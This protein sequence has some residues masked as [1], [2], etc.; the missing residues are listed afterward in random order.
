MKYVMIPINKK[1]CD[2]GMHIRRVLVS[3]KSKKD[4]TKEIKEILGLSADF[5]AKFIGFNDSR[6]IVA[7]PYFTKET[8][9][10]KYTFKDDG[11]TLDE[12]PDTTG[13][14]ILTAKFRKYHTAESSFAAVEPI[15]FTAKT[16]KAA[17]DQ[18]NNRKE[19]RD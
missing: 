9:S 16:D 8:S 15:F 6:F 1:Y 14:G 10:H 12:T 11:Y 5:D 4:I 13:D 17:I 18:F 19:L 2:D 7:D 3:Y